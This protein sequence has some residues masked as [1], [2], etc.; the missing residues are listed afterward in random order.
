MT[1]QQT[2]YDTLHRNALDEVDLNLFGVIVVK[3]VH[4]AICFT[5][6]DGI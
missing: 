3:L 4:S 1:P 5:S 6:V 2:S